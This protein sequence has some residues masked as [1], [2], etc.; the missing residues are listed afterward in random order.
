L[1]AIYRRRGLSPN[2]A[3]QVAAA[4][5]EADVVAAHSRD[6]LGLTDT[7]SANPLQAAIASALAFLAGGAPPLVIALLMPGANALW[8]I[9]AVTVVSLAV[10]GAIG[11]HLGGAPLARATLR[12]VGFGSLAMAVT[13]AVGKLFGAAV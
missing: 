10:L 6:E 11:A 8:G 4:L 13:A 12:V 7:N 9:V 3:Q 5:T 2:L 1:A